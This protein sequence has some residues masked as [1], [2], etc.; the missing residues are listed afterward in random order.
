MTSETFTPDN[1]VAGDYPIVTDTVTIA[2][3]QNL[4]RGAVLARITVGGKYVIVDSTVDPADG[5]EAP[6]CILAED[7]D[8]TDADVANVPVYL[9]GEFAEA[10][11]TFGGTDDADDHREALR[12]LNIYIKKTVAG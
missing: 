10:S 4:T 11:L 1:L 7:C 3:G 5:S 9:S 2:A 6:V 8:A 12:D